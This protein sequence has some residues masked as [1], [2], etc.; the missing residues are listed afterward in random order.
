MGVDLEHLRKPCACGE[1]HE[2]DVE[3]IH[4]EAGAVSR[5]EDI[6]VNYQNPVLICD[7][8]TRA[9]AEPFLEEEFKDYPV[10]ELSPEGLKPD[11]H[12]IGKVMKQ[13]D[14][15]D[16]GL[17]SV[18]VDVLVAI[19]S[20]TIHDLT[21]YAATEYD[22]PFVSVPTAASV[23]GFSANVVSLIWDGMK[24]TI[25]GAVPKWILADTDI[26]AK[27]PHRLTAS[28]VADLF[29][30]YT[31]I[32]DWRV[33]HLVTDEYICEEICE[34]IEHSLKE[35]SRELDGIRV[36]EPEAMEKLM[37]ALIVS[38]MTMQM[39][40]SPRP[41]SGAEH[42]A[43]HL[44]DMEVL[45]PARD[46]VLHGEEVG[47]ALVLV[48]DYYKKLGHAIRHRQVS[49]RSDLAKG[50]EYGLLEKAFSQKGLLDEILSGNEPNPLEDIDLVKL[51][52]EL[53]EIGNLIRDLPD[54]DEMIGKLKE[55]GCLTKV[56][57]IGL[58]EEIIED[59]L[60]ICPYVRSRMTLLR[61]AKLLE[62][63]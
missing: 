38:G 37:E 50:I 51:E 48:T 30:K 32:L 46:D 2:I 56:S 5:L 26:F 1:S 8:N 53:D 43:S 20:G 14:Y 49:V 16:R 58:D 36:G 23:D 63:Q 44:W 34:L 6:L 35:V 62:I 47:V 17:S 57:Q 39:A 13:L 24:K 60:A 12:G 54:A 31:A 21:R 9:A 22:I 42:M 40:K 27:A 3:E 55:A 29:A 61:L 10:I 45:N 7:S 18:S 41:V 15:C 19:G 59:T 28:G 52:E 11:N 25:P 4:I 33:S